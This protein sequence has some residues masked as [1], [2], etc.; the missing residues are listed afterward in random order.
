MRADVASKPLRYHVKV[1]QVGAA[2][3][4]CHHRAES[5][6]V[7]VATSDGVTAL[8]GTST[9]LGG[10]LSRSLLTLPSSILRQRLQLRHLFHQ[11]GF[12]FRLI[13]QVQPDY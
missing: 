6:F 8:F 3:G 2:L 12:K 9:G 4:G 10:T 7:Q 11:H 13:D 1:A 5:L